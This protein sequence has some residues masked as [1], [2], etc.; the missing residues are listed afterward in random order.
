VGKKKLT[1]IEMEPNE[2]YDKEIR[3]IEIQRRGL[4]DQYNTLDNPYDEHDIENILKSDLAY[5]PKKGQTLKSYVDELLIYH[6]LASK[7]NIQT[8]INGPKG[9]WY[10]HRNPAGCF[11]CEDMNLMSVDLQVLQLVA[12]KFPN[13]TF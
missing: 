1:V 8:H 2:Y 3:K 10:T 4:R 9:A 11:A 7:K 13:Y 5:A 6:K 12:A